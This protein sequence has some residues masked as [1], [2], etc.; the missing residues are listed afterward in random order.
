[1]IFPGFFMD[2]VVLTSE[3]S[4]DTKWGPP[5][6]LGDYPRRK[7]RELHIIRKIFHQIK[8]NGWIPVNIH[9]IV[10]RGR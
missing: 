6:Y 9:V 4:V 10:L 8:S 1:M 2:T 5:H 3:I 7:L